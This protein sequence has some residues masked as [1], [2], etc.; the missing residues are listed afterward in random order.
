MWKH[1]L[2]KRTWWPWLFAISAGCASAC[3]MDERAAGLNA[4]C[5]RTT[6]CERRLTCQEGVCA[7]QVDA[8]APNPPDRDASDA[9]AAEASHAD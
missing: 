9:G 5:T 7:P 2:L 1:S 8:S 4:P 3:G 6:D